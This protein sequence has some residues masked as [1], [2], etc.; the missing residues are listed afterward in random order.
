MTRLLLILILATVAIPADRGMWS[1]TGRII[2]ANAEVRHISAG[3]CGFFALYLHD[4][5]NS[6][7][8]QSEIVAMRWT[9]RVPGHIMVRVGNQYIDNHGIF[10]W[11][12]ISIYTWGN[13]KTITREQ[14]RKLLNGPGWN[15]VFNRADTAKLKKIFY[16]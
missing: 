14:L 11:F 8:I 13:R 9:H 6:R 10:T 12:A 2:S 1:V 3:G 7:G 4:Y 5:L 16:Q 15:P